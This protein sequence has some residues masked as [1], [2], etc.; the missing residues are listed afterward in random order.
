MSRTGNINRFIRKTGLQ[1]TLRITTGDEIV[2][3]EFIFVTYTDSY[4]LIPSIANK[5]LLN[6]NKLL[7]GVA[8]SGNRNWGVTYCKAMD[9]ILELYPVEPILKFELSGN[10]HD[11]EYF[12]KFVQNC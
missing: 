7:K 10:S 1:N 5:F 3:N 12:K 6:N 11:V 9:L 8:C 4:G 2:H